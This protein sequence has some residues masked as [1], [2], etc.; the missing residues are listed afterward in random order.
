VALR[1][2]FERSGNLLFRRR[3]YLPLI[4]IA[5]YFYAMRGYQYPGNSARLDMLLEF[6][7]LFVCFSG[8]AIRV[9]TIGHTPGG[10]SGRNTKEQIAATLNTTGIYSVVRHPLYLGNF[11]IWLGIILFAHLWWLVLIYVLAFW[12][13]YERI[14][15][16]EEEF[17]RAKFGD[18][19]TRWAANTPAFIPRF[20]QYI[21]P[22]LPFSTKTALKREY[23][24]AF[25]IIVMLFILEVA[26]KVVVEHRLECDPYWKYIMAAGFVMWMVLRTLKKKTTL[27]R[28]EGR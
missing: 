11:I 9:F 24:G 18:E 13:Y 21:P 26:S 6:F 20:G 27:L 12:L 25:A 8:L 15:F 22:H 19:F 14:M 3:S 1:E 16:A 4:L 10:T 17:L 28:V 23:N 5:V 2:E 7:C